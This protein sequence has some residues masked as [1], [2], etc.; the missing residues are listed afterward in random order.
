MSRQV[1]YVVPL[2]RHSGFSYFNSNTYTGPPR[3][4]GQKGS[5]SGGPG[6]P[7]V[8]NCQV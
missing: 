8:L 6:G 7:G 4:E 2:E 5:L 1:V 3:G